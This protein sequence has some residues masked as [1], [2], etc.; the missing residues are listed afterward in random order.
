MPLG[1]G[2]HLLE[3]EPRL[4]QSKQE[5][6]MGALRGRSISEGGGHACLAAAA[7]A[8]PRHF[9]FP[10][11]PPPV[12]PASSRSP[13]PPLRVSSAAISEHLSLDFPF[14]PLPPLPITEA[15]FGCLWIGNI[16]PWVSLFKP[17]FLCLCVS[18]CLCLSHVSLAC[19]SP[20]SLSVS[21]VLEH[22]SVSVHLTVFPY[23]S[24][25]FPA[26]HV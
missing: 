19:V 18:P 8:A 6:Q 22:L 12:M 9:H 10:C 4:S 13:P 15:K 25:S 2:F 23:V 20:V 24:A 7:S 11:F 1:A 26:S 14:C 16:C 21:V 3:G 17:Q 5:A